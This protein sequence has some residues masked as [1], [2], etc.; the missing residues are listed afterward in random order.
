MLQTEREHLLAAMEERNATIDRMTKTRE[1]LQEKVELAESVL[2]DKERLEELVVK[3]TELV[4]RQGNE[5]VCFN[6]P[7][8]SVLPF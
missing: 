3:Q 7:D 2:S 8:L 6:P 1:A 5:L 4:A